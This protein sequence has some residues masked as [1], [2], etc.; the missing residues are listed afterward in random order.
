MR[1]DEALQGILRL[2][3]DTA[4]F[5]YFV[6]RHPDYLGLMREIIRRIDAGEIE[7]VGSVVTL[8][9]VLTHPLRFKNVL[10]AQRYRDVLYRS[11]N[12]RL[13]PIDASIAEVAANLRARYNLRTP[14]ALQ[15]ATA[16]RAVAMHS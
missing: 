3:I 12:F 2:G 5:I 8:T 15:L 4:P 1:L 7:A 9:E 13:L 11:R 16:I 6:E 14:D 10:L